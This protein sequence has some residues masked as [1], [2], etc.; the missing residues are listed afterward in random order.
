MSRL[1]EE[2]A[3]LTAEEDRRR[4]RMQK[5][6]ENFRRGSSLRKESATCPAEEEQLAARLADV[7]NG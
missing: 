7:G 4:Q 1:A 6:A 3:R 5:P 2:A